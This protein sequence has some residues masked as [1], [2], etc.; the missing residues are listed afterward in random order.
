M[1]KV[2][3]KDV[4]SFQCPAGLTLLKE[5]R[6]HGI[7]IDSECENGHCGRCKCTIISGS[8]DLEGDEEGVLTDEEF[9]NG[10]VLA[11][12]SKITQDVT[13]ELLDGPALPVE[14]QE[15]KVVE[16]DAP[17]AD[18]RRI[19][20]LP[21]KVIKFIGGQYINAEFEGLPQRPYSIASQPDEEFLTLHIRRQERGLVSTYA[22][23]KLKVG[24][25]VVV[26]G[27]F[28]KAVL[29]ENLEGK[30]L[31]A[32]T[33]TGFAPVYAAVMKALKEDE[34][35]EVY[36]Y[37]GARNEAD[38]YP[39]KEIDILKNYENVKI[40][41][42][43]SRQASPSGI[44]GAGHVQDLILADGLPAAEELTVYVAGSPAMVADVKKVMVN[45]GVPLGKILT[46]PF[47][48]AKQSKADEPLKKG[49]FGAMFATKKKSA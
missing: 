42:A 30:I 4:A 16:I 5:V 17:I 18:V 6:K 20:L 37:F 45:L 13:I 11:C 22:V 7:K 2:T 9:N 21:S 40:R 43:L 46:D 44:Y 32:S 29:P 26:E 34:Q 10:V 24:E 1:P 49:F 8:V 47:F 15:A 33:G 23:D 28:G 41:I 14:K 48:S 38:V 3:I 27:P 31:G 36:L 35:K 25:T 19:K 39:K 12:C